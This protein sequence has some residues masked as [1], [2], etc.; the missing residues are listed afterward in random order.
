MIV[1]LILIINFNFNFKEITYNS[2]VTL[3]NSRIGGGNLYT[4]PQ[5]QYYNNWVSTYL[6][7]DPGLNWIIKKNYSSNENKKADEYVYDGDIIQI[8]ILNIIQ[9]FFY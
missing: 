9:F 7:N 2:T 5:I 6:N 3:K 4:S 8:G 1:I